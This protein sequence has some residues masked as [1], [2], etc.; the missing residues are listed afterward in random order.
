[1]PFIKL[2]KALEFKVLFFLHAVK[3]Y[4]KSYQGAPS[5]TTLFHFPEMGVKQLLGVS[6]NDMLSVVF[7]HRARL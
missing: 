1:M 5:V 3:E 4:R 7:H 2:Q 6:H